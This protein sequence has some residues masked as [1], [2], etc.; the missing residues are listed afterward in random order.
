MEQENALN[1]AAVLEKLLLYVKMNANRLANELGLNSNVV[2][3]H[4][5]NGRN[6]I[7]A[8]LAEKIVSRFPEIRYEWLLR[9]RGPMLNKETSEKTAIAAD[10]KKESV[11]EILNNLS[12]DEIITY[13][14]K[15]EKIRA[16]HKNET[17][18]MFLEIRIQRKIIES[19]ETIGIQQ[20]TTHSASN[21]T[22]ADKA[23]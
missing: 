14:H 18:K 2:I 19:L 4:I 9:G 8:D 20:K 21:K 3:Y 1:G 10:R 17:Y 22:A 16:F 7:S 15:H 11:E 6:K 5:K 23:L 12:I 13:I